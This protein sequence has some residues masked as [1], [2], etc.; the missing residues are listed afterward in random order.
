MYTL[1]IADDEKMIRDGLTNI[2]DW[3]ELG[4]E[5]A[6]ALGD[7]EEVIEYLDSMP[8]DVILTDIKMVHLSGIDIARHVQEAG[9]LCKV[10]FISGYKEFELAR[11]GIRYGVEDYILKP[12]KVEDITSVFTKIRQILD[13]RKRDAQTMEQVKMQ[14]EEAQQLLE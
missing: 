5:I 14:W 1:V 3:E 9:F 2:V 13:E 10:V 4:F 7:G 12:S 6:A 8:V 11:Q